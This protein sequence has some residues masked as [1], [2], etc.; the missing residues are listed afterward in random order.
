MRSP[1]TE[2]RAA[3]GIAG[4]QLR[5]YRVRTILA[6][7]GVA[8]AVLLVVMLGGLGYGMLTAGDEAIA[9]IDYDLWATSGPVGLAPGAVGDVRNPIQDAHSVSNRLERRRDVRAA[10][11]L[12]FQ[13]VYVRPAGTS[14]GGT[15]P[16]GTSRN[17]ESSGGT[18]P[19]GTSTGEEGFDTIV[20]V[21]IG[22]N[23][24]RLHVSR[25]AGLQG[26][27]P[28]YANG[29]Y[30]GPMTHEIVVD[31]RIAERYNLTVGDRLHVG[32]TLAAAR[33]HEF[34]VVGITRT[35]ST[36]LGV[37][38]V[39]M[40]LSELQE[41][42]GTTGTDPAALIALE[43]APAAERTAVQRE[44]ERTYP[45]LDVRTNDQQVRA[46]IGGQATIIVGA[47]TLVVLAVVAGVALVVNVLALLV[48]QQREQF[49]ALK[50]AGVSG[51]T[52]VGVVTVQGAL[53]GVLGGLVGLA[54]APLGVALVNRVVG[55]LTGFRHLVRTPPWLL[56]LGIGLAITMG[57]CGSLVAGRRVARIRPL[58]HLW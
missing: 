50:A 31:E 12:A 28:H 52:L 15:S 45:A 24:S 46:I 16:G 32:A 17:G 48:Y 44:L 1:G 10:Q 34:T 6:V 33:K 7:V 53:T 26:S 13:T 42:S 4:A 14:P 5:H 25:G 58:D 20:G 21:G 23:A 49:A 51:E 29:T 30:G 9:W 19:D 57:V 38:T 18:S 11:P 56:A 55:E 36:F 40:H 2:W 35:F 22:G 3:V 39:A 43:L 41:V 37:P 8:V 27:D 47:L 54:A